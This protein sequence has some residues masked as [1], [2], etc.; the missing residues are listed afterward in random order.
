LV[1]GVAWCFEVASK[2]EEE[3]EEEVAVRNVFKH[4]IKT[5]Q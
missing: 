5:R 4:K 3:E 1:R 2:R